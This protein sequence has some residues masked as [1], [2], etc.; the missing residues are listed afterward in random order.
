MLLLWVVSAIIISGLFLTSVYPNGYDK[1]KGRFNSVVSLLF[2]KKEEKFL[3]TWKNKALLTDSYKFEA[4]KENSND[5]LFKVTTKTIDFERKGIWFTE[6]QCYLIAAFM[7]AIMFAAMLC[8]ILG[9]GPV[10]AFA[11]PLAGTC[12]MAG[13]GLMATVIF[14]PFSVV[15]IMGMALI[16]AI[17]AFAYPL[18]LL[19]HFIVSIM[20]IIITILNINSSE[21]EETVIETS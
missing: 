12:L 19:F 14:I 8:T 15:P 13:V 10:F 4:I 2:P 11:R 17:L 5:V 18:L 3:V 6:G 16:V 9:V 20:Q 7:V 1:E 21:Q